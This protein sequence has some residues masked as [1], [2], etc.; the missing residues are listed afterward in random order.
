[1]CVYMCV[2]HM[3]AVI[4]GRKRVLVVWAGVTDGYKLS[5]KGAGNQTWSFARAVHVVIT[6][7]VSFWPLE[8][9]SFSLEFILRRGVL[10]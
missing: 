10:F 2:V 9:C 1:M 7:R 8:L 3:N 4:T 6:T 5:S